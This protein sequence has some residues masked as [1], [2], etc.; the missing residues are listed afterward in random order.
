[1]STACAAATS[2]P[3]HAAHVQSK[4]LKVGSTQ[5]MWP[6]CTCCERLLFVT[7]HADQSS[8]GCPSEDHLKDPDLGPKGTTLSQFRF[9]L[10]VAQQRCR[11]H[12]GTVDLL[13]QSGQP[14]Q[15]TCYQQLS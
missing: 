7:V 5:M 11:E 14:A 4:Y 13:S 8:L 2:V 15:C 3:C 9:V 6:L 12:F 1:M 10:K